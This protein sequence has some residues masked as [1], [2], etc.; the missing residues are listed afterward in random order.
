MELVGFARGKDLR[1]TASRGRMRDSA[2][3]LD[4]RF[5]ESLDIIGLPRGG[6][7]LAA[8]C[9]N[10]DMVGRDGEGVSFFLDKV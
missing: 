1:R 5:L 4:L 3:S 10:R 2:I 8:G 7:T 9:G 6:L